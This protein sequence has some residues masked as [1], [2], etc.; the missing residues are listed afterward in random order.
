MLAFDN[1]FRGWKH[2]SKLVHGCQI[3]LSATL[4]LEG[5]RKGDEVSKL[6]EKSIDLATNCFIKLLNDFGLYPFK[7]QI[8]YSE[9]KCECVQVDT[10]ECEK[11]I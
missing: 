10:Y 11:S 9:S 8:F 2:C 5:D 7:I 1:D 3:C 4:Y 6:K